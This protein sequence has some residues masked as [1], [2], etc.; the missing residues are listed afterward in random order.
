VIDGFAQA[1]LP[2][3]TGVEMLDLAVVLLRQEKAEEAEQT[4]IDATKIFAAHNFQYEGFQAAVLLRDAFRMKTATL[5]MV[6]EVADFLRRLV[7][8]PDLR[9]AARAWEEPTE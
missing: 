3:I 5:A 4:V 1:G 6:Q 8:D 7:Y 2:I 9:F